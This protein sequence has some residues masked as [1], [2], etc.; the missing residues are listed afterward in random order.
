MILRP[1]YDPRLF[2]ENQIAGF[3]TDSATGCFAD[4]GAWKPLTA[5]FKRGRIRGSRTRTSMAPASD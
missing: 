3:N 4:A 5:L 2:I 1:T